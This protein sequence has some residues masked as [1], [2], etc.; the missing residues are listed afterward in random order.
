MQFRH[1]RS[2]SRNCVLAMAPGRL[3]NPFGDVPVAGVP[4]KP[5]C[6]LDGSCDEVRSLFFRYPLHLSMTFL[7]IFASAGKVVLFARTAVSDRCRL[8]CIISSCY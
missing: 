6:S 5:F 2:K 1:F 7:H 3:F 4:Q 8:E